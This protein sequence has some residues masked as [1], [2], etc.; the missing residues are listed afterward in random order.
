MKWAKLPLKQTW[1]LSAGS[2]N[3]AL[4]LSFCYLKTSRYHYLFDQVI[5]G[6]DLSRQQYFFN[7]TYDLSLASQDY[8][9]S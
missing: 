9:T 3:V 5:N 6:I 1:T 4:K 8:P 7:Q 2:K